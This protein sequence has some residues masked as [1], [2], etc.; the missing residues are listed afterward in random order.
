MKVFL[1]TVGCKLNQSEIE[2]YSRKFHEAG[3]EIVASVDQADIVVINTCTVTSS[4]AQDSRQKLRQAIRIKPDVRL[5]A[6]G[7]LASVDANLI[8]LIPEIDQIIP[9]LEKDT[10]VEDLFGKIPVNK[11]S[12]R[13]PVAGERRRTRAFIKAQDGCDNYCT[14]CVTRLARGRSRSVPIDEVCEDIARAVRGGV[15]E[16]VLTGVQLG[17][18]GPDLNPEFTLADLVSEILNR[19][20]NDLRVRISS[21]EPWDVDDRLIS[22]WEDSRLC[23]HFHLPLQSG[24]DRTLKL[25]ARRITTR[26]YEDL[27]GRI[28]NHYPE[29]AITTDVIAGFPGETDEDFDA[30]IRLINK[31][32]FAGGHPFSYSARPG[33]PAA[34]LPDQIHGTVRHHRSNQLKSAFERSSLN[35]R[36][37]WLGKD[38]EVLW[39]AYHQTRG[40]WLMDGWNREYIRVQALSPNQAWNNVQKVRI[41]GLTEDGCEGEIIC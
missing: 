5:I 31:M 11:Q 32:Q 41:T 8:E 38:V 19:T 23:R 21:I 15:R 1:D 10:L 16:V 39:E 7:C 12:E 17:A 29:A 40:G 36:R 9:N 2:K 26:E 25:M 22:L 30:T 20:P 37:Q 33:T 28:R 4:A 3:H 14:F 6:T 13:I 27:I 18:W 35:F 34:R 24:S